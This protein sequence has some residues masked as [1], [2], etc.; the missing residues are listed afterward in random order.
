MAIHMMNRRQFLRSASG[1]LLAVPLLPSLVEKAYAASFPK[2]FVSI[3][4]VYGQPAQFFYPGRPRT[5]LAENIYH[6]AIPQGTI[7]SDIINT[8]FKSFSHKLSI[9]RGLDHCVSDHNNFT[10]L[11]PGLNV[12]KDG[13]GMTWPNS[14]DEVF[15]RSSVIYPEVPIE[16]ILRLEPEY[17]AK[18]YLDFRYSYWQG[19][20]NPYDDMMHVLFERLFGTI[21]QG[22][23]NKPKIK[24]IDLAF[25]A[26]KKVIGSR[27]ISS[28]DK[29]RLNQYT[30]MLSDLQNKI[31]KIDLVSCSPSKVD[32]ATNWENSY[33]AAIDISFLALNCGLTNVISL[34]LPYFGSIEGEGH[35]HF[36][37]VSHWAADGSFVIPD[38]GAGEERMITDPSSELGLKLLRYHAWTARKI[39]RFM[40]LMDSVNEDNGNTMLDNSL[41]YW[42]NETA[43]GSSHSPYSMPIVIG[44]SLNGKIKPGNWDYSRRPFDYYA[45][46]RDIYS[47]IG[48]I[49]YPTLLTSLCNI[50]GLSPSEY[51]LNGQGGFGHFDDSTTY[52]KYIKDHQ[53]YVGYTENNTNK[54]K[55][56][57]FWLT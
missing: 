32:P 27:K 43:G 6:D 48:T 37:G 54:R 35:G 21:G 24:A 5:K 31:T 52:M 42:G 34:S 17:N 26:Y 47:P 11:A 45:G 8:E 46:R 16:R 9:I 53:K 36:H 33:D 41:V 51:E 49:P 23:V 7:I 19:V 28:V 12:S 44:G 18:S 3:R 13:V 1:Y 4:T 29:Q 25:D 56:L 57:P 40:G 38:F 14:L 30:D 15:A 50:Y 22:S 39:G 2:R 10:M 20:R 55:T